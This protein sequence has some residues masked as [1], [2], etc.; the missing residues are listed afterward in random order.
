MR[1]GYATL[2]D[3]EFAH[4]GGGAH[5][6]VRPDHHR[7]LLPRARGGGPPAQ[8]RTATLS[9]A[10]NLVRCASR[11]CHA[12][13]IHPRR[14]IIQPRRARIGARLAAAGHALRASSGMT[15]LCLLRRQTTLR[16]VVD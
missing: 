4:A 5:V 13:A 11:R 16:S 9:A 8:T 7:I 15:S 6:A 14:A 3:A 1:R 10:S 12:I 2:A